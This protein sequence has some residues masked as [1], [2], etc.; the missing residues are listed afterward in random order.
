MA[1]LIL[2]LKTVK[3]SSALDCKTMLGVIRALAFYKS[4]L[5]FNTTITY[6]AYFHIKRIKYNDI[7]N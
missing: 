5:N 4:G 1:N 3:R 6:L 7:S 2:P